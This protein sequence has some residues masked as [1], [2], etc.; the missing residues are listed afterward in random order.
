MTPLI[1]VTGA[2]GNTGRHVVAGLLAEGYR[3]RALT[4]DPERAALPEGADVVAGDV[5]RPADVAAAAR[6]ATAAYLIWPGTDDEAA[7]AGEVIEALARRVGRVVYLS[8]TEA[9]E[10][11]VW[12]AV[13]RAI[14]DSVPQWTF[15]RVSGLAVNALAWSDQ[16]HR[17]VVR[18]PFGRMRRSLVHEQDVAAVAVRALVDDGHAGR[19]YVL[20]GP[21]AISQ[22]D[23]VRVI[24]EEAEHDAVWEEQTAADA[25]PALAAEV[26]EDFADMI[27]AAWAAS[28]D[29]PEPVSQDVARV[30]G[31]PPLTFRQWAR[32]HRADFA[33]S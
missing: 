1:L 32:D 33:A 10:G 31:R 24:A 16:I 15:L 26:G 6:G 29:T 25:R 18:A 23:Q 20:T 2:T 11:G 9:E 27:L 22:I 8:A 21:E 30:L 7:G 19:S 4:R 28:A 12:G 14:R 17:G 13:E 5:R 3:V